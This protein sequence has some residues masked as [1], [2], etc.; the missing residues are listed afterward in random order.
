MRV[1]AA[2]TATSYCSVSVCE[3]LD[4]EAHVLCETTVLAGR[5]H[6]ELLLEMAAEVLE[7]TELT[8][9]ALDLLAISA[10]PGSF[11]GLRV[12][13]RCVVVKSPV[14]LLCRYEM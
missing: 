7:A 2:D 1:L 4:T 6:S 3:C 10:G 9:E 8:L 5:R 12:V 14:P 11:T 13:S